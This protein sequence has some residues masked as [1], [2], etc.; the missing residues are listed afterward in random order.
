MPPVE[1]S[2][3]GH[4]AAIFLAGSLAIIGV[5]LLATTDPETWS[6][7]LA[8]GGWLLAGLFVIVLV[9]MILESFGL[10][11][12]VN[13]TQERRISPIEAL[14]L[15]LESYF[16][17][18]LIPVTAAGVPYQGFLLVRKG[19]RAGW[20][21]AIVLVKG[22]VPGIFFFAVL[23]AVAAMAAAG[24][25]GDTHT[26]T[27]LKIVGPLA[28]LPTGFIVAMLVIMLRYPRLFDR[29]VE[30]GASFLKRKLRG[31]AAERIE[32]GSV[33]LRQ[34]SQ[35]FRDALRTLWGCKRLVLLWGALLIILA[36]V[37]EFCVGV[38]I[39]WGFG[40]QGSPGGPLLLQ[41]V[42]KP[43]IA[44]SPTPGSVAV[45]EGGYIAFFA[46]YLPSSYVG[47]SLVLWRLTVYFAPMLAGAILVAK[48]IGRR[49]FSMPNTARGG[50]S[51]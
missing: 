31:R 39:L 43:V 33:V 47:V 17:G 34:E 24:W 48:R 20:A 10:L 25:R 42:L 6:G 28:A 40:Y 29:L 5:T 44:A 41:A 9:R 15:T 18:Q 35:V 49:G 36:L 19:V 4:M 51:S 27:F 23:V 8:F 3:I 1:R 12:L 21:T 38:V 32:A 2:K 30:R 14:E 7:V 11:I 16:V 26:V 50:V 13:G 37:V 22:F 46:A 45:G